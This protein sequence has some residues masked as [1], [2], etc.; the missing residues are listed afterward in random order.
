MDNSI[1]YPHEGEGGTSKVPPTPREGI[2]SV[3]NGK[4]RLCSN[5]KAKFYE[6]CIVERYTYVPET[7]EQTFST[8][9]MTMTC[10]LSQ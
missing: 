5:N 8:K 2:P 7:Y 3:R 9:S 4:D 1:V 6:F 10:D